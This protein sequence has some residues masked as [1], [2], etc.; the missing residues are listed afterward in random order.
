M[1]AATSCTNTDVKND[2][3]LAIK[4]KVSD[5]RDRERQ[6]RLRRTT[7][8]P[9]ATQ[10]P[11]PAAASSQFPYVRTCEERNRPRAALPPPREP[12][13]RF[14]KPTLPL[15]VNLGPLGGSQLVAGRFGN[16]WTKYTLRQI[17]ADVYTNLYQ[18]DSGNITTDVKVDLRGRSARLLPGPVS[19]ATIPFSNP[20]AGPGS[21]SFAPGHAPTAL[22][23]RSSGSL[24]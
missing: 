7:S 5:T 9:S 4:G 2:F 20:H 8:T 23:T 1:T 17:D 12:R 13:P 16:Q 24:A 3:V 19:S 18:T 22:S 10:F 21:N 11:V 15:P 6:A 14:G